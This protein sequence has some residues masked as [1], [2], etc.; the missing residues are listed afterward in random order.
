MISDAA[1]FSCNYVI[2][3]HEFISNFRLLDVQGYDVILGAN[4]IYQ[5]SPVGL[6]L[7]RREFTLTQNN[8]KVITLADEMI[9]PHGLVIGTKKL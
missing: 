1:C 8:S 4:W 2:Q 3:G 5:H 7:K 6:D 9:H